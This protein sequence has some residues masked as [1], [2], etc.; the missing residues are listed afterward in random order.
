MSVLEKAYW[1]GPRIF[2]LAL[3]A[4][5]MAVFIAANIHLVA[6]ALS[7]R[8]DCVLNPNTEGVATLRAARPSC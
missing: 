7:S 4:L 3:A 2:A 5:V 6:V 8:P 1:T